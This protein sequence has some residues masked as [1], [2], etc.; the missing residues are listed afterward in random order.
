VVSGLARGIDAAAHRGALASGTAAVVAGGVDVVYPAENQ[1]LY[2]RIR[3]D[4]LLIAEQA[5][6]VRP[7]PRD[8]PRRNRVIAGMTRATLVVEASRRSGSLITARLALDYGRE[9]MAV[10]GSPLDGRARGANQLIREGA[11]LVETG[12]D[13]LSALAGPSGGALAE[14]KPHDFIDEKCDEPGRAELQAARAWIV[15]ALGP[16][17][18]AVDELVRHGQFSPATAATVL[19]E[20]ELAGRLQRH[21]GNQVALTETVASLA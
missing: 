6:G 12:D 17:P 20:L 9:V 2:D 15:S 1:A 18:V 4:G 10:P 13:V 3:S 5:P 16:S 19:L 8:F 14:G 21:P 11:L 7:Q